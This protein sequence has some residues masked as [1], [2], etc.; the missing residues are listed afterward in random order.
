MTSDALVIAPIGPLDH[1]G[2][3]TVAL[4]RN[5]EV[6]P[7]GEFALHA[8]ALGE[9][10]RSP[11]RPAVLRLTRTDVLEKTLNLPLAAQA[12]LD[13]RLAVEMDLET[14]SHPAELE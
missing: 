14:P 8:A 13:Q 10:P 9:L 7:L 6:A 12:G 5:G 1:A 4:S 11:N 3:I 2:A